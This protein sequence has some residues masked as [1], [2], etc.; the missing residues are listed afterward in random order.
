M[1]SGKSLYMIIIDPNSHEDLT[2]CEIKSGC[3]TFNHCSKSFATISL[4]SHIWSFLA[5]NAHEK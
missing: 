2:K 3:S 1:A 5:L 4:G